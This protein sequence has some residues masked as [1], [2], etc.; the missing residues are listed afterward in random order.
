[1][2]RWIAVIAG[3]ICSILSFYM[4]FIEFSVGDSGVYLF[5]TFGLFFGGLFLAAVIPIMTSHSGFFRK[6]SE[7]LS[8]PPR[9]VSFV[10]H[11]F[12]MAAIITA[13]VVILAV[14]LVPVLFR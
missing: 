1:M 7:R 14:I 4:A 5:S 3:S 13:V 10:P 12:I 6:I 11:W 2:V 9:P 8:G